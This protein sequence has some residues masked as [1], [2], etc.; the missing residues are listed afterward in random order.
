M[1]IYVVWKIPDNIVD[2]QADD[3]HDKSASFQD[4][5]LWGKK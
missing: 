5:R 2:L 4:T 1:W 3:F